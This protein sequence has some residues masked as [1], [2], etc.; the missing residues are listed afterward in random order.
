[1]CRL[2]L[3]WDRFAT[4]V[5][6][7]SQIFVSKHTTRKARAAEP[8]MRLHY[9]L[10]ASSNA[11]MESKVI[12]SE[13]STSITS[14]SAEDKGGEKLVRAI[15]HDDTTDDEERALKDVA[16]KLRKVKAKAQ[17]PLWYAAR[18]TPEKLLEELKLTGKVRGALLN[19]KNWPIYKS[20]K[21]FYDKH[22]LTYP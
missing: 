20:Y 6:R 9:V 4:S 8:R 3:S 7:H 12:A 15:E 11:V 22:H 10:L 19:N 21:K 18:K 2:A 1:M 17:F 14:G 16:A 13:T 5:S